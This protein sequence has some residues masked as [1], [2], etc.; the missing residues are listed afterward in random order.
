MTEP[1]QATEQELEIRN[2]KEKV[3]DKNHRIGDLESTNERLTNQLQRQEK[4]NKQDLLDGIFKIGSTTAAAIVVI[5]FFGF[6]SRTC[7]FGTEARNNAERAAT[8]YASRSNTS[9]ASVYCF[10]PD[11]GYNSSPCYGETTYQCNLRNQTGTTTS[12]VC[13]DPDPDKYNDGC[14]PMAF[15]YQ[16][17]QS[18]SDQ[19]PSTVIVR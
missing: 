1:K 2:L 10:R 8:A 14:R 15:T 11:L 7:S 17:A 19:S 5:L 9:T 13:C 12:S 18:S 6:V 16:Q 4:R 3:L